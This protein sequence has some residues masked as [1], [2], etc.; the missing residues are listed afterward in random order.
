MPHPFKRGCPTP[1]HKAFEGG[2]SKYIYNT[3]SSF[4]NTTQLPTNVYAG[5]KLLDLVR[6][7]TPPTC[8]SKINLF[9]PW[10]F[11]YRRLPKQGPRANYVA[12]GTRMARGGSRA[13]SA[14]TSLRSDTSRS[15]LAVPAK[16]KHRRLAAKERA[17]AKESNADHRDAKAEMLGPRM[18]AATARARERAR[19]LTKQA[20]SWLQRPPR[21]TART[22]IFFRQA[23]QRVGTR[24][25]GLVILIGLLPVLICF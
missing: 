6:H 3:R 4:H 11:F 22:R 10:T 8:P 23:E 14:R 5:S 9:L 1:F 21:S 7:E 20:A 13:E 18:T 25:F 2:S 15:R 16:G 12:R 24:R 17:A 19:S